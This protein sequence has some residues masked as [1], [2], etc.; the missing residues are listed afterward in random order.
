MDS[1][2]AMHPDTAPAPQDKTSVWEDFLDI[3]YAPSQVFG[4]RANGNFWIPL[5]V[6]TVLVALLAFANRHVMEPIFDAEFQRGMVAAM[7]ANP[8]FTPAMM[9][10]SRSVGLIV[11]QIGAVVFVPVIVLLAGFV[12]WVGAKLVGAKISWNAALVVAAYAAVP[13]VLQ[14]VVMSIQ[15][16]LMDPSQFVSRF[17]I[18]IGP[19]RFFNADT[20]TPMVGALLDRFDL[21]SLWGVFLLTVG[22]AVIGKVP[23]AKAWAL[24][25]GFWVVMMLP[26]LIGAWRAS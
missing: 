17:S 20:V 25:V 16:L 14:G 21:F 6:V 3:F 9:E 24:G 8:Q 5:F 2:N 22:V 13:R 19:A 18:E 12:A 15:G 10:K 4:R 26:S 7:K 11:A 23:R 1:P